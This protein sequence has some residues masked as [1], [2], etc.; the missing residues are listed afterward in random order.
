MW[1]LCTVSLL[2]V[3]VLSNGCIEKVKTGDEITGD[4]LGQ[5]PPDGAEVFAPGL[6]CTGL[7]ERDF[8]ISPDGNEIFFTLLN[9]RSGTII[10]VGRVDGEW[11]RPEIASFSGR[12]SDLEASIS[13]DGE[14]LYFASNRPLEGDEPKDYDIWVCDREDGEWGE[15]YNIGAPVN[16]K[17]DEFYPSV[18]SEGT[19]YFTAVYDGRDNADDVYRAGV[20]NGKYT[21][22]EM[23]PEQINTMSYEYNAFIAP[24]ES[25][26]IYT[27]Y[28]RDDAQGRGD[29]YINFR[30]S[31]GTWSPAV[32]LGDIANSPAHDYCP[33]VTRDNQY[34]FFTSAHSTVSMDDIGEKTY[35]NL[36]RALNASG[37]GEQDIYWMDAGFIRQLKPRN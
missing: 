25:Y 10:R 32:N 1:K 3:V 29:M 23:L 35:D 17:F 11:D 26:I 8:T 2:L 18:T 4:Y 14:K 27:A 20:E 31:D 21:D 12:Y 37:N 19:L 6:I 28:G 9:G 13:P 7:N 15:P 5:K 24:D 33:F 34:L 36:R 16:T 22:A 30:E